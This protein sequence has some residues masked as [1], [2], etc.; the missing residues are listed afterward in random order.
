MTFFIVRDGVMGYT[1]KT[2]SGLACSVLIGL[3]SLMVGGTA[4]AA[5]PNPESHGEASASSASSRAKSE[6]TFGEKESYAAE[7][8]AEGPSAV[9]RTAAYALADDAAPEE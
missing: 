4:S 1:R 8:A 7:R 2:V 3:A 5:G 6:E 9:A